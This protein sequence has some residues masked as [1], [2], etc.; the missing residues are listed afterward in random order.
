MGC[1]CISMVMWS[2]LPTISQMLLYHSLNVCIIMVS[3]SISE[4]TWSWPPSLP[5]Y[6]LQV[7]LQTLCIMSPKYTQTWPLSACP[8]SLEH[9]LQVYTIIAS[10]WISNLTLSLPPCSYNNCLQVHLQS[11]SIKAWKRIAMFTGFQSSGRPCIAPK[12]C[13]QSVLIYPVYID[14]YIHS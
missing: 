4:L 3:Q 8:N 7:Y 12:H 6:C 1:K 13:M 11:C 2:W 10:N 5:N 9:Y 14:T